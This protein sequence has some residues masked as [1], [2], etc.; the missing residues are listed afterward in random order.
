MAQIINTNIASLNAQRNLTTSQGSL[1]NSLQRLSSGLR[2][3]SAKDDAAGLAISERFSA[4]IRGINQATRN[5]NDGISL[6]QT[7]EGALAEVGNNLQRIRELAVQSANATNSTSDRAALQSEVDQLIAEMDRVASQTEF[8][9]T[10]LLDGN[11]KNQK[12]QVGA[13]SGQTIEIN[14][15]A[16]ARTTDLGARLEATITGTPVTAALTAGDLTI[17]GEAINASNGYTGSNGRA[18]D[19][20]YAIAAAINASQSTV[21]AEAQKTVAAQGTTTAFDS[22][23]SGTI[24]INGVTTATITGSGA[25]GSNKASIAQAINAVSASSGVTAI[26]DSTGIRLEAADGRNIEISVAQTAGTFTAAALGITGDAK[27]QGTIKLTTDS[28]EGITLGGA[29][30]AKAG[31]TDSQTKAAALT[32]VSVSN[33]NIS[34]FEGADEAIK[35][36]DAALKSINTS[37]AELGAIQN[38]F[39]ST[40]ANLQ[41]TSENLSA[42]RGRI[43]DADFATETAN[44]TRSQILQQAGTAMLAQAN[45]LPQNVLSLLRG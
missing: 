18:A 33:L 24:T 7:A 29:G 38:R 39:A 9:G 41:T 25:E 12:F 1:A 5:A 22:T 3:N 14:N 10:R 6:S 32:G 42:S 37:R 31:F 17:N 45:G 2:I 21:T 44:L 43:V 4:Q 26:E 36:I 30:E 8:N 13:N 40:I 20:A 16:S 35:T 28:S 19:S 11:F 23:N 34:T 15:I 27:T